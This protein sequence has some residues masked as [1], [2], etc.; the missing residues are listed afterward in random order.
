ML[1]LQYTMSI[2]PWCFLCV[3]SKPEG[4]MDILLS[5]DTNEGLSTTDL[6]SFTYQVA[7]GMEFLASKN[8]RLNATCAFYPF[9]FS[10]SFFTVGQ[11]SSTAS[12]SPTSHC[13]LYANSCV[14][15]PGG[16]ARKS[17]V[18]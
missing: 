5:D 9:V 18:V 3:L 12:H 4:E 15:Q 6:L 2:Y 13:V 16:W 8:V 17:V 10:V 7:K 11:K 1:Y 14:A